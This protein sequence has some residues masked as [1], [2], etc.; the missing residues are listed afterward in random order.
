MEIPAS[1]GAEPF[2]YITTVGRTSGRLHT[3][4]LWF[5]ARHRRNPAG[6]GAVA[7]AAPLVSRLSRLDQEGLA[8]F[9]LLMHAV[10]IGTALA[11][12]G[13]L[14]SLWLLRRRRDLI[15]LL[16][17]SVLIGLVLYYLPTRVHERYLFGAVAFLAPLA[18][19][20]P[21][22]RWPFVV[23]SAV[24]FLTLAYVV[25][26]IAFFT[27]LFTKN[28]PPGLF[29]FNVVALRWQNRSTAY[30]DWMTERYPPWAWG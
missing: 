1:W 23:L 9:L 3:V 22:L 28:F 20:V 14:G 29:D 6:Y 10:L 30:Y 15:G 12:A 17:V 4:E 7:V 21:R 2:C 27:I 24:F 19:M 13:I 18:A 11:I 25:A 5:A 16:G 26:F 8:R